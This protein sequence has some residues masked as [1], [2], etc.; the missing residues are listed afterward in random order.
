ML[1]C[2]LSK[3]YP[4]GNSYLTWRRGKVL[5]E[6]RI[7]YHGAPPLFVVGTVGA[8]WLHIRLLSCAVLMSGFVRFNSELC[9]FWGL[10]CPHYNICVCGV[11]ARYVFLRKGV[12]CDFSVTVFDQ[13]VMSR[14]RFS[15]QMRYLP[16]TL[17]YCRCR[18]CAFASKLFVL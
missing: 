17:V 13:D 8:L 10:A 15:R 12:R 3:Y 14:L 2:A 18:F 6:R 16:F 4:E 9:L 7:F 11:A 1:L 5:K